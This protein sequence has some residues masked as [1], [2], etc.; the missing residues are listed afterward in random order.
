MPN[1]DALDLARFLPYRLSVLSNTISQRIAS[2]Y[3][4]RFGLSVNQWRAMAILGRHD[5][6]AAR[7]VA[8]RAAMDKVAVS[9]AVAALLEK[10]LLR[11]EPAQEDKRESRLFLTS[12]GRYIHD[13]IVPLALNHEQQLLERLSPEERQW[14][15]R[16]LDVLQAPPPSRD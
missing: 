13:Q 11:R 4:Q 1:P 7:D 6:L 2:D 3:E 16:I 14:L 5:G 8:A 9:R 15:T 12:S 10:G